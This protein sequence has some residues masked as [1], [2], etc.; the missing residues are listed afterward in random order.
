MY[1]FVNNFSLEAMADE[2]HDATN[3][4][5]YA[6][7]HLN[8]YLHALWYGNKIIVIVIVKKVRYISDDYVFPHS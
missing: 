7:S 6:C 4:D 3:G 1:N 8:C 2:Y 5:Y